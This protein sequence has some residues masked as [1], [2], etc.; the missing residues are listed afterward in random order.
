M[1]PVALRV[2]KLAHLLIAPLVHHPVNL[3]IPVA[4]PAH[5]D[6]SPFANQKLKGTDSTHVSNFIIVVNFWTF[7]D[8]MFS[9]LYLLT[10][11]SSTGVSL[12]GYSVACSVYD[13]VA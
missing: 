6:P 8:I 10:A 9:P 4:H 3:A 13:N 5:Q 12:S 1:I 2:L 7:R 11:S